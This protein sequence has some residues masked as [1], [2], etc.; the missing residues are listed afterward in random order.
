MVAFELSLNN[1]KEHLYEFPE[2]TL[3]KERVDTKTIPDMFRD[4]LGGPVCLHIPI[5]EIACK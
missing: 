5:R 2:R 3:C 4:Q 1:M